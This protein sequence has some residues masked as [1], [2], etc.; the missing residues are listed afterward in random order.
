MV[1]D[2]IEA[3]CSR[4]AALF[5]GGES[6]FFVNLYGGEMVKGSTATDIFAYMMS[7]TLKDL[8]FDSIDDYL[9]WLCQ[10]AW[11]Y[12]RRSAFPRGETLEDRC[13]SILEQFDEIGF[14]QILERT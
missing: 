2:R 5:I 11:R 3:A 7:K 1:N 6:M 14:L 9:V 13:V 10:N 4:K 8:D 12:E